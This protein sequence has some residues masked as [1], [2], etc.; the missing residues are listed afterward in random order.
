[1]IG[2]VSGSHPPDPGFDESHFK[3]QFKVSPQ[4]KK[5]W[6]DLFRPTGY[7][8]N[9]KEIS[10]MTDQFINQVWNNCN[11][12]LKHALANLKKLERDRERDENS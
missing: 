11:T 12:V 10:K 4:F 9:D 7:V 8:P 3:A 5:M 2:N 6:V 1:M